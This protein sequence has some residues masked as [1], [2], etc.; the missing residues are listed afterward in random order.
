MLDNGSAI[1]KNPEHEMDR[2]NSKAFILRD[3]FLNFG[4]NIVAD[5]HNTTVG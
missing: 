3:L 1:W 2:S 4:I 5:A